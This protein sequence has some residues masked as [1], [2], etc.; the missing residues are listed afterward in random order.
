MFTKHHSCIRVLCPKR[1]ATK[2]KRLTVSI[3]F[4]RGGF[5]F[6]FI[7][8]RIQRI[9]KKESCIGTQHHLYSKQHF[10]IISPHTIPI[11]VKVVTEAV[12]NN[13]LHRGVLSGKFVHGCRSESLVTNNASGWTH[14]CIS[15]I[16]ALAHTMWCEYYDISILQC[17]SVCAL[18]CVC[19][20]VCECERSRA[21]QWVC[22]YGIY[23]KSVERIQRLNSDR[24]QSTAIQVAVLW[25]FFALCTV[26]IDNL[27]VSHHHFMFVHH[28]W[29]HQTSNE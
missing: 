10:H 24:R 15:K 5:F 27:C 19:V 18:A 14:F 3:S 12:E 6:F 28:F 9:E 16:N 7:P 4:S 13:W 17:V 8:S 25:F 22:E 23:M 29:D 2:Y 11:V 26:L 21:Q 1:G 20:S